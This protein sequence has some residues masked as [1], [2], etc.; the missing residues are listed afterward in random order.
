M[1]QY[2]LVIN[3]E[4][5]GPFTI[6]QLATQQLTPE[7]PVWTEGMS[8]WVP[9]QQVAELSSLFASQAPIPEASQPTATPQ[10]PAYN[11]APAYGNP[12][13]QAPNTQVVPPN[14]LVWSILVTL[15]CCIPGGVVAI[16]YS[17]QVSS[18]FQQ[19]DY[20]GAN[21][22]S[23]NARKWVIISAIAAAAVWIIYFIILAVTGA[24]ILALSQY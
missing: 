11:A 20:A 14:Y 2:Y 9:A 1:K 24:S 8:D 18:R 12:Q 21:E 3:G 5:S 15:F 4:K 22:S 6:D 7:T 16:V 10:A 13:P 23:R 19:G 17:T